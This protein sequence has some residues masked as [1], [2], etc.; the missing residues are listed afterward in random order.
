MLDKRG[1]F[2]ITSAYWF[3]KQSSETLVSGCLDS[4]LTMKIWSEVWGLKLCPRFNV[5]LWKAIRYNLPTFDK[6]NKRTINNSVLYT[7]CIN[8]VE[9]LEHVLFECAFSRMAWLS[10]FKDGLLSRLSRKVIDRWMILQH[11]LNLNQLIQ[12]WLLYWHI[13]LFRNKVIFEG[14]Q[15]DSECVIRGWKMV[16]SHFCTSIW[17]LFAKPSATSSIKNPFYLASNVCI[18]IGDVLHHLNLTVGFIILDF[19]IQLCWTFQT[20]IQRTSS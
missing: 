1:N 18:A 16:F 8:Q 11:T 10:L 6:Q 4:S 5:S 9:S 7:F 20:P 13:L 2:S 12:K 3:G 15:R 14:Q 17:N 19:S